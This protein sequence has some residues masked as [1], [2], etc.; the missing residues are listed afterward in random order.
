LA[1]GR[2]ANARATLERL[3]RPLA[4]DG[5]PLT[6]AIADAA[7]DR[8]GRPRTA[9]ERGRLERAVENATATLESAGTSGPG[10]LEYARGALL[11]EL[12]KAT[13]G[14]TSLRRV[15]T[16]P[17]RSLSHALARGALRVS[18]SAPRRGSG[19]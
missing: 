6:L 14:R 10:L 15:F 5:A 8:L 18:P 13:E 12:G 3:A 1:C 17:D 2:G 9:A 7:R 19:R 16:Y 11:E 4:G